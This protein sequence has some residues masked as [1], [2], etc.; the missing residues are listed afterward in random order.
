[1]VYQSIL[2]FLRQF[3]CSNTI[4]FWI[5]KVGSRL[6]LILFIGTNAVNAQTSNKLGIAA[7][8]N[9]D[10]I[11]EFDLQA[12]TRLMLLSARTPPTPETVAN[13]EPQA[14]RVL[15]DENLRIQEA[16]RLGIEITDKEIQE[17]V[18]QLA[19]GNNLTA[20]EFSEVLKRAGIPIRTLR[21][22][23]RGDIAWA[24]I[25]QYRLRRRV[26]ISDDEVEVAL[27][28]LRV[29]I[30]GVEVLL[31]EIFLSVDPAQNE[32][33]AQELMNNIR[34]Q[35]MRNVPFETLAQQFSESATA[36]KGGDMGWVLVDRLDSTLRNAVQ[37][38]EPGQVAGPVRGSVGLHL[39]KIRD[40]RTVALQSEV[41][42]NG[43]AKYTLKQLHLPL[44]LGANS[45]TETA[46]I[47]RASRLREIIKECQDIDFVHQETSVTESGDLG[48]HRLM[49]LP[50]EVRNLV[51]SLEVHQTTKPFRISNGISLI[52]VCDIERADPDEKLREE[53]KQKMISERVDALARRYMRDLRRTA[54]I[55]RRE[56]SS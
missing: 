15:I 8:V 43:E 45:E 40:R 52:M 36:Q 11:S 30:G 6:V 10:V 17:Q 7:V 1:M 49:D 50:D 9:D 21:N 13:T 55:D 3:L 42:A 29:G 34:D 35:L 39:I 19:G 31:S 46:T 5:R 54:V 32:S 33:S 22:Q 23:F 37:N 12:R 18:E 14:M 27:E 47:M 16:E 26:T 25:V 38:I 28:Q 20:A 53:I 48:Q 2:C 44:P 4:D 51:Q 41:S 24:R 56:R